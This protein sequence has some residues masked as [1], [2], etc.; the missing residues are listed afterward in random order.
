MRS[1]LDATRKS[2]HAHDVAINSSSAAR[3]SLADAHDQDLWAWVAADI[4][5]PRPSANVVV[6]CAHQVVDRETLNLVR[7]LLL[8]ARTMHGPATGDGGGNT[9]V[10]G[11]TPTSNW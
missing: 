2:A 10:G 8:R 11:N 5:S 6:H 3:P 7:A 9:A 4:C 1:A